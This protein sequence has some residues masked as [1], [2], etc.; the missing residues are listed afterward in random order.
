MLTADWRAARVE[1]RNSIK[2]ETSSDGDMKWSDTGYILYLASTGSVGS[3][4]KKAVKN[5][6]MSFSVSNCKNGVA[7]N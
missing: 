3:E 1:T 4:R 6:S 5:D 2:E 7:F